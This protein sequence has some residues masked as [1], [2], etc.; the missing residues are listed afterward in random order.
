LIRSPS[1]SSPSCFFDDV[2][3][4]SECFDAKTNFFSSS[5]VEQFWLLRGTI[6]YVENAYRLSSCGETQ[7][8]NGVRLLLCMT[9]TARKMEAAIVRSFD[10][11]RV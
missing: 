6:S 9:M 3:V 10:I 11:E 4:N 1:F 8:I 7:I 2:G 5:E